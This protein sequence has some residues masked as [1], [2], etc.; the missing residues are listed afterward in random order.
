M[1]E[2]Q[3][4]KQIEKIEKV[5]KFKDG[6]LMKL[7]RVKSE[8]KSFKTWLESCIRIAKSNKN[9]DTEFFLRD[10]LEKYKSFEKVGITKIYGWK[11]KSGIIEL[12]KSPSK[13]IVVRMQ[14]PEKDAEPKR[15]EIEI[16]KEEL[17]AVIGVLNK[18]NQGDK[19]ET[20]YIA[21]AYSKAMGLEHENW[22]N[23]FADRKQHNLL[24]NILGVLDA[25]GVIEYKG[26]K[27]KILK[28]KLDIQLIL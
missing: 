13:I 18:L 1:V 19:I 5:G 14:R 16:T 17:N 28:N 12:I 25:E 23:F 10:I 2:V 11:G 7:E 3:T 20:K 27:T 4:K 15:V 6:K 8:A 21:M 24:T 26:G 9:H 22:K